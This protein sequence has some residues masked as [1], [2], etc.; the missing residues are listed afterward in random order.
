M[1]TIRK[2]SSFGS[3]LFD[4]TNYILAAIVL[5]IMVYPFYYIICYSLSSSSMVS[6]NLLFWPRGFNT[7]A[8]T[9][10][11]DIDGIGIATVVSVAR[12]VLGTLL[13]IIVTAQCGYAMANNFFGK[14]FTYRFFVITMYLGAGMIPVYLIMKVLHLT[15]SFMV[16]IVPSAFSSFNMILVKTF[17]ESQPQIMEIKESAV[18]DGAKEF[19]IFY[20]VLFPIIKPVI[21]AI[22]LFCAVGQWDS[23]VDTFIYNSSNRNLFTLQYLLMILM[24]N[25]KVNNINS[26]LQVKAS[27][28]QR[29]TSPLA[30][31]CAMTIVV[32]V[33]IALVYPSLQKHFAKG[34]LIG[35]IKA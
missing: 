32:T 8:Y 27:L 7:D 9:R 19:A 10:M 2:K 28:Q 33:P 26:M 17:I 29:V 30:L 6:G 21:A 11:L 15:N 23:Y 18:I 22:A 25:V 24:N 4:V 31:Q 13:M 12:T 3:N 5:I 14:R 16:Y 20:K 34:M 1:K 35:A